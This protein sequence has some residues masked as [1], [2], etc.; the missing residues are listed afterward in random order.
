MMAPGHAL[1][2]S[3][4]GVGVAHLLSA[5]LGVHLSVL[6]QLV[7][8]A[9]CAGAALLPDLDHPGATVSRAFGP[10]SEAAARGLDSLGVWAYHRTRTRYD[11]PEC[12]DGHRKITHTWPFPLVLGGLV[13]LACGWGGRVAVLVC[14]FVFL[15][16]AVRGLAPRFGHDKP[17]GRLRRAAR[18]ALPRWLRSNG[19]VAVSV[20][21]AGLTALTA[22]WLGDVPAPVGAWLGAVVALGCYVH[23]WGDGHTVAGLPFWWPLRV[24]GQRWREVALLPYPLRFHAGKAFERRAVMPLLTVANVVVLSDVTGLLWPALALVGL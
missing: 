11:K 20:T 12:R 16:L 21:A 18:R 1:H 2:G 9:L 14:L 23:C 17:H 4:V 5:L 24:R 7:A 8:G 13:A 22:S 19:W 3:V 6:V 15:S 10:V